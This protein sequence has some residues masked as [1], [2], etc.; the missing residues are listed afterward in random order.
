MKIITNRIF[1]IDEK[2]IHQQ[3]EQRSF[4]KENVLT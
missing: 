4:L 2:Q 3:E 1:R